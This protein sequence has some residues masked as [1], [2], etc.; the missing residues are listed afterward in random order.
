MHGDLHE[1]KIT[2]DG[3]A[4]ITIYNTT[5]VD[6][7]NV[8]QKGGQRAR[9]WIIDGIFQE[10]D[11]A[12]NRLLFEWKASDHFRIEDS[13]Y[14]QPLAGYSKH[15]PYDFFHINSV[16]KDTSGNYLV[17][18]RHLHSVICIHPVG[19]VEWVLGGKHN[20]FEDVFNSSATIFTW[21]HDAR[22]ASE[23]NETHSV[24]YQAGHYHRHGMGLM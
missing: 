17:S 18:S 9:Q 3:T 12:S 4:L 14:F 8:G 22:W 1:F 5:R 2:Q 24:S 16:D 6:P 15:Y 20:Q 21:Q 7:A 19:T 11:I 13:F 10:I 23:P